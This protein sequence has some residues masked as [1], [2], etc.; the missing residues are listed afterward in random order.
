MSNSERDFTVSSVADLQSI[1]THLNSLLTGRDIVLLS[2]PMGVGKT[3]LVRAMVANRQGEDITSP[4]FAIHNNYT[5]GELSI[6]HLDLFRIEGDDD[7]ESTGFWDLFDQQSGLILLEW[8]E[9]I[10]LNSLPRNWKKIKVDLEFKDANQ[11][12]IKVSE[13]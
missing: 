12:V 3:E 13:A 10:D 7:L 6:D 11:R 2:G 9:K 1:V 5:A 4:S 8:A